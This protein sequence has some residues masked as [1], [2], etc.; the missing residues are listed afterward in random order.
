MLKTLHI[1]Y[2]NM[3]FVRQDGV[4][5]L[6]LHKTFPDTSLTC[7]TVLNKRFIVCIITRQEIGVNF[8][9]PPRS[10]NGYTPLSYPH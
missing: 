5:S 3:I 10:S 8:C 9:P 1:L 7:K 2:F 4:I 6:T